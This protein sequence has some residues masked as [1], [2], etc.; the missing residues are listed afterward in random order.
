[1]WELAIDAR[2]DAIEALMPMALDP[3]QYLQAVA[4][5]SVE[6]QARAM[7][8]YLREHPDQH[9]DV[10]AAIDRRGIDSSVVVKPMNRGRARD[11]ATCF[12]FLPSNTTSALVAARRIRARG[13]CVDVINHT[14]V[15]IHG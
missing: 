12:C 7:G 11:L 6:S 3:S 14:M 15:G 10:L 4:R 5:R 1:T 8:I 9:Q 13:V 2:L